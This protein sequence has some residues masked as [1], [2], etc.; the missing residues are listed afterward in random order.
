[1]DL[2]TV[3]INGKKTGLV[4]EGFD[5]KEDSI[6]LSVHRKEDEFPEMM[7]KIGNPHLEAT[8][9]I[10]NKLNRLFKQQGWTVGQI[11]FNYG[12]ITFVLTTPKNII[13][14]DVAKC[15][16]IEHD[17][18]HPVVVPLMEVKTERSLHTHTW[19]YSINCRNEYYT[20]VHGHPETMKVENGQSKSKKIRE[21]IYGP[22]GF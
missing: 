14:K 8:Q 18:A 9:G 19:I 3:Y 5:I 22:I 2:K 7:K 10:T 17:E 11:D 4:V 1:M 15:L 6:Y 13:Q 20:H 21:N 16:G 12:Y